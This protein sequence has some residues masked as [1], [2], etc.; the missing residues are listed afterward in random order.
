MSPDT[1]RAAIRIVTRTVFVS[2]NSER[3]S[4]RARPS[5]WLL[6]RVYPALAGNL[7]QRQENCPTAQNKG[8]HDQEKNK[9]LLL[10]EFPV[11]HARKSAYRSLWKYQAPTTTATRTRDTPRISMSETPPPVG[12]H[13]MP[14]LLPTAMLY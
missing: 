8:T 5:C 1:T 3:K 13:A 12:T 11:F 6:G 7:C 14:Q 2:G 4:A 9:A 10:G